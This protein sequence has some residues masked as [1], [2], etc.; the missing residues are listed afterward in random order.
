[1]KT[2]M[3][4]ARR[5]FGGAQKGVVIREAVDSW[6]ELADNPELEVEAIRFMIQMTRSTVATETTDS[7]ARYGLLVYELTGGLTFAH[8]ARFLTLE[9]KKPLP[10]EGEKG[11]N[12]WRRTAATLRSYKCACLHISRSNGVAW[13]EAQSERMDAVLSGME[14]IGALG[15]PRGSLTGEQCWQIINLAFERRKFEIG[16]GLLIIAGSVVRPRDVTDLRLGDISENCDIIYAEIKDRIARKISKGGY[17]PKCVIWESTRVLL[18]QLRE[19]YQGCPEHTHVLP[20]FTLEGAAEVIKDAVRVYGWGE[21]GIS[22]VGAHSWRHAGATA[23]FN[24]ALEAARAAGNWS[25]AD[26]PLRYAVRGRAGLT[27]A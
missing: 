27:Q 7:Y 6:R 22:I 14:A 4:R 8:F 19:Y 16:W 3:D 9:G 25:G 26:G 11:G 10:P 5:M 1:M 23:V 24:E 13:T 12:E 21:E 2:I 17:E 18:R 20:H 15:K